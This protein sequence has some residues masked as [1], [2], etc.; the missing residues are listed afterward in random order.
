MEPLP[1]PPTSSSSTAAQRFQSSVYFGSP[2]SPSQN[3]FS[4]ANPAS[5]QPLGGSSH[6]Q[7]PSFPPHSQAPPSVEA[8]PGASQSQPPA[9][10]SSK[11]QQLTGQLM[12]DE[13]RD[14]PVQP[15]FPQQPFL[16]S[17]LATTISPQPPGSVL[18]T[19]SE[20]EGASAPPHSFSPSLTSEQHQNNL[21]PT[22]HAN[23]TSLH[24]QD[25]R[26]GEPMN[27]ASTVA[28]EQTPQVNPEITG[29][30][31]PLSH[32]QPL[33]HPV[34]TRELSHGST[35]SPADG[36]SNSL[37]P[38]G[39]SSPLQSDHTGHQSMFTD[40]LPPPPPPS[41]T[42][43]ASS[44]LSTGSNTPH[45]LL[46]PSLGHPQSV[47]ETLLG[48]NSAL[49]QQ[50]TNA[51]SSQET[52]Y[53][54]HSLTNA[55]IPSA[56]SLPVRQSLITE[57]PEPLAQPPSHAVTND[58]AT[59]TEVTTT[60]ST[61]CQSSVTTST[62][63]THRA[64]GSLGGGSQSVT[65]SVHSVSSLLNGDD[66]NLT[67]QSPV[68]LIPPA[69][70][71][72]SS[73]PLPPPP[74]SLDPPPSVS[75]QSSDEQPKHT[76][77]DR[78]TGERLATDRTFPDHTSPLSSTS[79]LTAWEHSTPS[80][81]NLQ[82]ANTS[83]V[84]RSEEPLPPPAAITTTAH[85]NLSRQDQLGPTRP[86]EL[87]APEGSA[88]PVAD[89]QL[90]QLHLSSASSS[91][92][93]PAHV[94]GGSQLTSTTHSSLPNPP[95]R[96]PPT[97]ADGKD[98]SVSPPPPAFPTGSDNQPSYPLSLPSL[99]NNPLILHRSSQPS[100][101]SPPPS[102]LP[103]KASTEQ[104][105]SNTAHGFP[106]TAPKIS[107][108][109][110]SELMSI[111]QAKMSEHTSQLP[112]T[113]AA[114]LPTSQ[115]SSILP[116]PPIHSDARELPSHRDVRPPAGM[117]RDEQPEY[118]YHGEGNTYDDRHYRPRPENNYHDDRGRYPPDYYEYSYHYNDPRSYNSRGHLGRHGN[119]PHRQLYPHD[120]RRFYPPEHPGYD[121][122]Y[123][124]RDKRDP[125]YYRDYHGDP[126]Y[127]RDYYHEPRGRRPYYD[128]QD[129]NQPGYYGD[130]DYSHQH[131]VRQ[132]YHQQHEQWYPEDH[133]GY[134][135]DNSRHQP[136]TGYRDH[137]QHQ[138]ASELGND[139]SLADTS[140]IQGR[141]DHLV[142]PSQSYYNSPNVAYAHSAGQ[143]YDSEP[144][145]ESTRLEQPVPADEYG[146][147]PYHDGERGYEQ[148]QG[149]EGEPWQPITGRSVCRCMSD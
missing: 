134:E 71:S 64:P 149:Y 107:L 108:P 20:Q 8:T 126:Y 137:D 132:E 39:R 45:P 85:S 130:R 49:T 73:P 116:P 3:P 145:Y 96:R 58:T 93:V 147:Y 2:G 30:M 98:Q 104:A 4:F 29:E 105:P 80:V 127:D 84:S 42:S 91:S 51:F 141:P 35:H 65:S 92:T 14:L 77:V 142:D 22:H 67:I 111:N 144:P 110:S 1:I 101:F 19:S 36:S 135:Y 81:I 114:P 99:T 5:S 148:L 122:R 56:V 76:Q 75:Q 133:G 113:S 53:Q 136:S 79:T 38:N 55:E 119:D 17:S 140:A 83:L 57:S 28:P 146:G 24:T 87:A 97:T 106:T 62:L 23:P 69:D 117:E 43:R 82:Q 32:D 123:D 16:A 21:F 120:D 72:S 41:Q 90:G 33:P 11:P 74:S 12:A 6:T 13:V 31:A 40:L 115:P 44:N 18:P 61:V 10:L 128:W 121:P 54:Y 60:H 26:D 143:R 48:V 34:H 112:D 124:Y 100:A 102:H 88:D 37:Y 15:S 25:G 89:L 68:K 27:S 66:E 109:S 86:P 59:S 139:I 95:Q 118:Y 63:P 94:P 125:Y 47:P 46:N 138:N 70:L 7:W 52:Q 78:E 103:Q 131:W 9:S 129:H 50:L